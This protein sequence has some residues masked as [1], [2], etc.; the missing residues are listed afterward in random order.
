MEPQPHQLADKLKEV[1]NSGQ[2]NLESM[3]ILGKKIILGPDLGLSQRDDVQNKINEFSSNTENKWRLPTNEEFEEV[4]KPIRE[5]WK[6]EDLSNE[7]KEIKAKE[8]V[9][10]LG[11]KWNNY[12]WTGFEYTDK[13]RDSACVWSSSKGEVLGTFK[14]GVNSNIRVIR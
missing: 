1:R 9:E 3:D 5:I 10:G 2:D 12:Y 8:V 13:S 4:G 14:H 6:R 11:F 7:E